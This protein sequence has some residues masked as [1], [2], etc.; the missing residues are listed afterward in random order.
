MAR[1]GIVPPPPGQDDARICRWCLATR[2]QIVAVEGEPWLCR[3][4]CADTA[5]YRWFCHDC[6]REF[7]TGKRWHGDQCWQC[8]AKERGEY[9]A[10]YADVIGFPSR[11][12]PKDGKPWRDIDDG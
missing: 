11:F 3:S 9:V 4:G 6:Q 10:S 12:S 1:R 5:A 8:A 7:Y 2:I